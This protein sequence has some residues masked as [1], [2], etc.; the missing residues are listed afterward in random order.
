MPQHDFAALYDRIPDA[1][2]GLTAGFTSHEFI[3]R[4]ARDNQGLYVAALHSYHGSLD[5]FR[6]VH[7]VLAQRLHALPQLVR[8]VGTVDSPDI[9][10]DVVECARWERV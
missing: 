9:F 8:H 4:L 5:P 7:A 1:V 6:R 2:A 10:G 3:Q